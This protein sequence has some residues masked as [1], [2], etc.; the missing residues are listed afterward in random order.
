MEG[1]RKTDFGTKIISS[2]HAQPDHRQTPVKRRA[3]TVYVPR[4]GL[5]ARGFKRLGDTFHLQRTLWFREPPSERCGANRIPDMTI[6]V[7]VCQQPQD[8]C[9]CVAIFSHGTLHFT[10]HVPRGKALYSV[11]EFCHRTVTIGSAA[12]VVIAFPSGRTAL[13]YRILN[14]V[15]HFG[16]LLFPA[17]IEGVANRRDE[18]FVVKRLHEKGDWPDGHCGG[19]RGQILSRGNDNYASLG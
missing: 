17:L 18:F 1:E 15:S 4:C 10:L 13:R 3:E 16:T 11:R 2:E 5:N 7:A 8:A 12:A 14:R 19:T 9:P 6:A